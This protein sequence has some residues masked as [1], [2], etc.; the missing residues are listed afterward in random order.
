MATL[1]RWRPF[2]TTPKT[3]VFPR[4][5]LIGLD[6]E[7][8]VV[9]GSGTVEMVSP[10]SFAFI[11]D[12]V[13]ANIEY[14]I[15]KLNRL[16]KNPYDGSARLRLFGVDSEG[17]EWAGG[18]TTPVVDMARNTWRF[19]GEIESLITVDQTDT[20][21]RQAGTELIFGLRVG[22]PMTL[23]VTGLPKLDQPGTIPR[24]EHEIEILGSAVHL[25]YEDATGTFVITASHSPDL[26]THYAENWLSE[27]LRVLF[28]Q[29]IYPRI[30]ARNFGDGRANIRVGRS[31]GVI[32]G[33]RWAAL[34]ERNPAGDSRPLWSQYAQIL[35]LVARARGDDGQPNFE[36]HKLTRLYEEVIQAALGSRWVWALTF[37]SS[38]EALAQMLAP[39]D[40]MTTEAESAAFLALVTHINDG[41]GEPRLKEIAVNA[42]RR[43]TKI[44]A[45]RTLRKLKDDGV[46]EQRH[47]SAWEKIRNSVMHGSLVSPYSSAEDD[48]RL[49][50]L[51]AMM[52]ALTRELLRRS[53][54]DSP[55]QPEAS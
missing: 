23:A 30:I 38:I 47:L 26:P 50:S 54:A 35:D 3:L 51:A 46:I 6:H 2:L 33:A 55:P 5:E 31:P 20:V 12:G 7:P 34:W 10:T 18:Y 53:A 52:H 42:V 13:P 44:T 41:P 8:S 49:L 27:P 11:L 29:L 22:D 28:G 40:I 24:R 15:A 9:V 14:A 17:I 32:R 37:A 45:I 16:R 43:T 4:F 21:S 39:K 19:T 1:D 25:A 48:D 36:P